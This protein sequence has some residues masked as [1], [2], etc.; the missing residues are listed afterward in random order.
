MRAR[1]YLRLS[2]PTP[3]SIYYQQNPLS[4]A[5]PKHERHPG[6][7]VSNHACSIFLPV[8]GHYS[9][10]AFGHSP[11]HYQPGSIQENSINNH[12]RRIPIHPAPLP[13]PN[14]LKRQ[15]YQSMELSIALHPNSSNKWLHTTSNQPTTRHPHP[16]SHYLYLFSCLLCHC[17]NYQH[18]RH[19]LHNSNKETQASKGQTLETEIPSSGTKGCSLTRIQDHHHSH[20]MFH[21][22][23]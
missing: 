1:F 9:S 7:A 14:T 15:P 18:L 22:G 21:P 6:P 20:R 16:G 4:T 5:Q 17:C 13:T 10:L 23:Q 3:H 8:L 2:Y 11:Y 12:Y 19:L